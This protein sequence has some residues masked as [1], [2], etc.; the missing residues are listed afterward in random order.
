M[1]SQRTQALVLRRTNYGEADRILQVLTPMGKYG[2]MA[3]GVR[4]EKSRLAGSIELFSL[5]DIVF[6]KGRGELSILTSASIVSSYQNIVKDYDRM[7]FGYELLK[8]MNKASEMLVNSE[9]FDILVESLVGLD[10]LELDIMIVKIW[11]YLR[12]SA[13]LG[14]ELNIWRD[15]SGKLLSVDSVYRY[16]SQEQGLVMDSGG[17][18]KSEHIKYLRIASQKPIKILAQIG[19]VDRILPNCLSIARIHS[20]IH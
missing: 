16:D 6:T 15:I 5:T 3:K 4:R 10:K 1:K 9:C 19:G 8:Q 20:G 14:H 2:L 18:I 13:L 17:D 11:F 7:Q 12:Y